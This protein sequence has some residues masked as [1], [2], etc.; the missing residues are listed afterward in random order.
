[1]T[2]SGLVASHTA[3]L[4][5][6]PIFS[7][8]LSPAI[9]LWSPERHLRTKTLIIHCKTCFSHGILLLFCYLKCNPI[10]PVIQFKNFSPWTLLSL[11]PASNLSAYPDGSIRFWPYHH[12][13]CHCPGPC[14]HQSLIYCNSCFSTGL[15][16][17]FTLDSPHR[18][19][20]LRRL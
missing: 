3:S 12:I 11:Y 14:Y 8:H 18:N 20:N 13:H 16:F 1:M 17:T 2:I 15:S 10:Y 9:S 4:L 5:F 6:P 7:P 19:Q